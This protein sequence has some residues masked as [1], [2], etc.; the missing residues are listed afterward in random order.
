M[1]AINLSSCLHHIM[2]EM[3]MEIA[4][5]LNQA[6]VSKQ[7]FDKMWWIVYTFLDIFHLF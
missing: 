5:Y 7:L 2:V 1:A 3:V 6:N 4:F